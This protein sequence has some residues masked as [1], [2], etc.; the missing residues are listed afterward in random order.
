MADSVITSEGTI[1]ATVL[2]MISAQDSAGDSN[3][4]STS[5]D[6]SVTYE[7]VNSHGDGEPEAVIDPTNTLLALLR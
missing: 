2:G 7:T 5:T 1:V 4:D 3:T 6:I